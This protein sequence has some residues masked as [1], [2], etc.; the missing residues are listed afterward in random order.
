EFWVVESSTGAFGVLYC[1]LR[2]LTQIR[3]A[4]AE[5]AKS[6]RETIRRGEQVATRRGGGRLPR[7]GPPPGGAGRGGPT[8][9][10]AAP[11]RRGPPP[12][13]AGTARASPTSRRSERPG[14]SPR[15][16][17]AHRWVA[18]FTPV[19][20]PPNPA[21]VPAVDAPW[22]APAAGRYPPVG[23]QVPGRSQRALPR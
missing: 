2:G 23:D 17:V 19:A 20:P 11:R 1:T 13:P 6:P 15:P 5:Y 7:G 21:R 16:P 3:A 22:R 14:E 4:K 8:R 9:A 18:E 12:L 10:P